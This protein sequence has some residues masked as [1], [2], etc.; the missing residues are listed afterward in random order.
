MSFDKEVKVSVTFTNHP[1][2][3]QEPYAS[4]D[5]KSNFG[6]SPFDNRMPTILKSLSNPTDYSAGI[7][8]RRFT[9]L[10]DKDQTQETSRKRPD[11][12]KMGVLERWD[13]RYPD[14][15]L[16]EVDDQKIE[17]TYHKRTGDRCVA[18]ITSGPKDLVGYTTK[19]LHRNHDGDW[20]KGA[21]EELKDLLKKEEPIC[22]A[23]SPCD[24]LPIFTKLDPQS[25]SKNENRKLEEVKDKINH[26]I[27]SDDSTNTPSPAKND[28]PI[29]E[30]KAK[31]QNF[32][33]T[34]PRTDRP[35]M[36][37]PDLKQMEKEAKEF[38]NNPINYNQPPPNIDP[39]TPEAQFSRGNL[40]CDDHIDPL[41]KE[42]PAMVTPDCKDIEEPEDLN[43]QPV[44]PTPTPE[45]QTNIPPQAKPVEIDADDLIG[46]LKKEG[47]EVLTDGYDE[48]LRLLEK[49]KL[50][51]NL[52]VALVDVLREEHGNIFDGNGNFIGDTDVAIRI[53]KK[54]IK[55]AG[56]NI[57]KSVGNTML[58]SAGSKIANPLGEMI[59]Q[60]TP[61]AIKE[62]A[63]NSSAVVK[64]NWENVN[65]KINQLQTTGSDL[66]ATGNQ[67]LQAA[68]DLRK[69]AQ[70]LEKKAQTQKKVKIK[71]KENGEIKSKLVS[72][73]DA[74]KIAA[75]NNQQSLRLERQGK[76]NLAAGKVVESTGKVIKQ[77]AKSIEN[78]LSNGAETLVTNLVSSTLDA[79]V[80][81]DP[82]RGVM[83]TALDIGSKTLCSSG[84]QMG[85]AVGHAVAKETIKQLAPRIAEKLPGI[86]KC[87]M[88]VQMGSGIVNAHSLEEAAGNTLKSSVQMGCSYGGA[89]I[90]QA[91]I[92]IPY[93]GGAIGGYVGSFIGGALTG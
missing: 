3:Y 8:Q 14:T 72:S 6:S 37:E 12:E 49:E 68:S 33:D 22:Y 65:G 4:G 47:L 81:Y 28:K 92:P 35:V 1:G 44:P 5:S 74:K 11:K 76:T 59:V 41:K 56:K 64:H 79:V 58:L 39:Q 23:P 60:N 62:F 52:V 88:M 83:N 85:T 82:N 75:R 57:L 46:K 71:Y 73:Q 15:Q 20:K 30:N 32:D 45:E 36:P 70:K 2:S 51:E 91:L 10:S 18:E 48:L 50:A 25:P 9:D 38:W 86:D 90:G 34:P 78:E 89:L 53:G 61:E 77:G 13:F 27:N 40:G 55:L 87:M 21:N 84:K 16:L 31:T 93:V 54:T 43:N 63:A 24:N 80:N 19:P 17:V 7:G 29:P 66:Q 26:L 42:A 69:K 67:K